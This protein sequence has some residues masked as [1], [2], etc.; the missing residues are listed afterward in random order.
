MCILLSVLAV[1][2]C[3]CFPSF[4]KSGISVDVS[5]ESAVL[6]EAEGGEIIFE[7][8]KDKKLPTASTT[9]IMTAILVIEN[10]DISKTVEVDK[11][12]VG[13]KG[14]TVYL[15][16]NQRLSVEDLLYALMLESANDAAAELALVAG[17]GDDGNFV[18]MMNEKAAL[19]GMKNTH[20]SNPHGLCDDEH[21]STAYDMALL[22]RYAM[23]NDTFC[24]IVSSY[25]Y[26]C[27]TLNRN[28]I[29]HNRLLISNIGCNGGKTGYTKKSG[30]CLV[31]SAK[32]NETE[33]ISVTL[34][35]PDDWI[36]HTRL[37]ESAYDK[38]ISYELVTRGQYGFCVPVV[39]SKSTSL[40]CEAKECR[41]FINKSDMENI[42]TEVHLKK[43]YY[44]GIKK[45]DKVGE[46]LFFINDKEI[47]RSEIISDCD[48]ENIV[49]KNLFERLLSFFIK[50]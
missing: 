49:Y 32:R 20:F 18:S 21:Y 2:L 39:N 12:A 34:N 28:F 23:R 47:A 42:R 7:K 43:F 8:D 6:I 30:R 50:D 37:Y 25:R 17:E 40:Y 5:A 13:V 45:G 14:S 4:A 41:A 48:C 15:T 38:Y 31:S 19:L 35:A 26:N 1:M 33:L 36:D 22:M 27:K 3:T 9:K 24:T 44:G 46:M 10:C 16:E 29:N 11:R